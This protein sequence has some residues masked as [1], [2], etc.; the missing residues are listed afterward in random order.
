MIRIV[1]LI[2]IFIIFHCSFSA[3]RYNS[4]EDMMKTD[5]WLSDSLLQIVIDENVEQQKIPYSQQRFLAC[6]QAEGNIDSY[7]LTLY[8][9]AKNIKYKKKIYR[10]LYMDKGECRII[11]HIRKHNLKELLNAD[12]KNN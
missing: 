3:I 1:L 12:T 6:A 7:L 4:Y 8:P 5:L 2:N 11:V 9:N 10:T